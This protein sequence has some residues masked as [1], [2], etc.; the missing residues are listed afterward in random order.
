M[1]VKL[2]YMCAYIWIAC[3]KTSCSKRKDRIWYRTA[4]VFKG[5]HNINLKD[6]GKR[7]I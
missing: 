7:H 2:Q 6:K 5:F 3:C 1:K 4:V